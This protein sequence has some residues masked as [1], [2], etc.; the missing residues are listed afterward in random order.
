MNINQ[1]LRSAALLALS[2]T[3]FIAAHAGPNDFQSS[4]SPSSLNSTPGYVSPELRTP[5]YP[6]AQAP[7]SS[8][9]PNAMTPAANPDGASL[10]GTMKAF[11]NS[12][13]NG[14]APANAGPGN[15][16]R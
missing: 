4:S 8:L 14:T 10:P 15:P 9:S 13:Q 16:N 7:S 1:M 5:Q 11:T 6:S 12:M 3:P 2:A